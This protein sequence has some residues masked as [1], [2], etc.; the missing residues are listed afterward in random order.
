[1]KTEGPGETSM[2][3]N[4]KQSIPMR[5]P[6]RLSQATAE[7]SNVLCTT[8]PGRHDDL[9][10]VLPTTDSDH[11]DQTNAIAMGARGAQT[12]NKLVQTG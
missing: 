10:D 1:M 7:R 12:S 3:G 2:S 9:V 11:D 5:E 6:G 8:R 4:V